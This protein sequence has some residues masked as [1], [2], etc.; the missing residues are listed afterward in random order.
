MQTMPEADGTLRYS[1]SCKKLQE[2]EV[3]SDNIE[4][5][6]EFEFYTSEQF[7][8]DLIEDLR[9]ITNANLLVNRK[10][11]PIQED[12]HLC[13]NYKPDNSLE[14]YCGREISVPI[15]SIEELKHYIIE[16]SKI[17]NEYSST[18]EDTGFHIHI[19]TQDKSLNIDFYAFMLL[20]EEASLLSNWGKRNAYSLNVMDVLGVFDMKEAKELKE[21]KG[22]IW[23]LE[24]REAHH[25]EIRTIGGTDYHKQTKKILEELEIFTN[26]FRRILLLPDDEY[27]ELLKAHKTKLKGISE[28]KKEDFYKIIGGLTT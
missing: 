18:N 22:R 23:S 27:K 28:D 17:L 1:C 15:C 9:S 2:L 14:G 3:G 10:S 16:I 21:K 5:G 25:I 11:I 24:K 7:E 4:F 26:I 20:C 8:E 13:M 6:C 12:R 19:S